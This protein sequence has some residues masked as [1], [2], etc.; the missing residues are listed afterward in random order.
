MTSIYYHVTTS[1][2]TRSIRKHGLI[3]ESTTSR[4]PESCYRN[5]HAVYMFFRLR[6]APRWA[7]FMIERGCDRRKM[8]IIEV[9]YDLEVTPDVHQDFEYSRGVS[10]YVSANIPPSCLTQI[11]PLSEARGVV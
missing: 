2:R 9:Q 11:M 4:W 1:D 8:R 6:H 7:E 10:C 5:Y 3:I